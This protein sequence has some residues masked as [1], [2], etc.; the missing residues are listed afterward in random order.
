MY[1][2]CKIYV[3][4]TLSLIPKI[5]NYEKDNHICCRYINGI[6]SSSTRKSKRHVH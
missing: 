2:N 5:P 1:F 4:F 3:T 6:C